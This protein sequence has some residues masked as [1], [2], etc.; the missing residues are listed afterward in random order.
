MEVA[1]RAGSVLTQV[2][3]PEVMHA[4]FST[5]S[6]NLEAGVWGSRFPMTMGRLY[7]GHLPTENA[8]VALRELQEIVDGLCE[9]PVARVVWDIEH[10]AQPVPDWY[11]RGAGVSN[12][13]DF[14]VTV[15]GLLLL[16]QG[17]I[18]SVESAVEFGHDV[19]IIPFDQEA[20][21]RGVPH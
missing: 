11:R 20:F 9:L 7:E 21:L 13:A 14:F 8:R 15:N 16:R 17:L 1:I 19:R 2:G 4:L 3:P 18:E 12:V 10:P 6:A 5:V